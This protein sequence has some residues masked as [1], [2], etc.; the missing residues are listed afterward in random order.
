MLQHCA[1][2]LPKGTRQWCDYR[3]RKEQA[4]N[5]VTLKAGTPLFLAAKTGNVEMYDCTPSC[6]KK[7][8]LEPV[9]LL[10]NK[11]A[12][13]EAID[14]ERKTAL[15]LAAKNGNSE[16]V[17]LLL[18]EGARIE[19]SPFKSRAFNGKTALLLAEENGYWD[20]V[21]LLLH[22]EAKI[23]A[24]NCRGMSALL[25]A[26]GNGNLKTVQLL[27]NRGAKIEAN[28][29]ATFGWGA[30]I[31]KTDGTNIIGDMDKT[32][33]LI[34]GIEENL[35]VVQLL[36][37]AGANVNFAQTWRMERTPLRRLGTLY[38][39]KL[40]LRAG[41]DL[42]GMSDHHM[43][44]LHMFL[45]SSG[46]A[47]QPKMAFLDLLRPQLQPD[48]SLARIEF[49][50]AVPSHVFN[51]DSRLI[52]FGKG[53]SDHPISDLMS[54][55]SFYTEKQFSIVHPK[56]EPLDFSV[57]RGLH[58]D[59]ENKEAFTFRVKVENWEEITTGSDYP[60]LHIS[61]AFREVLSLIPETK[62]SVSPLF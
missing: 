52:S 6:S 43:T 49:L 62:P 61:Q 56:G 53:D 16:R 15:L 50:E 32:A 48:T 58:L 14:S 40:L 22:D 30:N 19:A 24:N 9:R 21:Q 34:A 26:A 17:Q 42:A 1:L 51:K 54:T 2:L 45:M 39:A 37:D 44:A 29:A 10:L 8:N 11:S 20:T 18:N 46:K 60:V 3:F 59:E 35:E 38:G 57:A 36:L 31:E 27:L 5:Q 41:V 12:R 4:S 28:N 55:K 25:L 13:I 7:G 23:E 33:L 47:L